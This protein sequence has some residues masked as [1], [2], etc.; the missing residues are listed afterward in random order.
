MLSVVLDVVVV[1]DWSGSY[2]YIGHGYS[3]YVCFDGSRKSSSSARPE[4]EAAWKL[5]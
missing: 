5:S 3:L 2:V 1:L 4:G